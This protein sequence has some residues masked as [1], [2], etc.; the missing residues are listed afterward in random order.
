M[1]QPPKP[2]ALAFIK[3]LKAFAVARGDAGAALPYVEAH[4]NLRSKED[5]L[6]IL[7]T[8]VGIIPAPEAPIPGDTDFISRVRRRTLLG[9]IPGM[10][11]KPFYGASYYNTTLAVADWVTEGKPI[12]ATSVTLSPFVPLVPHKLGVLVVISDAAA[13]DVSVSAD[14]AFRDDLENAFGLNEDRAFTD[15]ANA[16]DASKPASITHGQPT[17]AS[18]G[19]FATDLASLAALYVGDLRRAVLLMNPADA[20]RAG[21]SLISQSLGLRGGDVMGTPA[22]VSPGVPAGV[23]ALIDPAQIRYSLGAVEV[24]YTQAATVQLDTS[25]TDPSTANV[26]VHSLWQLNCHGLRLIEYATWETPPVG[27]APYIAGAFQP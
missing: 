5:V 17:L 8:A 9:S 10:V 13:R 24:A 19:D 14:Y 2:A 16:G 18:T 15:P 3:A 22:F 20:L 11:E 23:V 27:A 26:P 1:Y 6:R 21:S 4:A 7:R 12:P 25:P